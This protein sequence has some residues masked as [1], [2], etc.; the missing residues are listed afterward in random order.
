[1]Q[2]L[3]LASSSPR[4]KE[5]LQQ[6]GLDF[7]V[8]V[9]DIDET[10]H[11][12]EAA[13][14]YVERMARTKAQAVSRELKPLHTGESRYILA[15]DTIGVLDGEILIKPLDR[16]DFGRMMGRM[17]GCTHQVITS[18]SVA[19]QAAGTDATEQRLISV[20][21]DVRFKV[22]EADEIEAYWQ[23]SEPLDK[24]GGYGIQSKGALFVEGIQGSYSNVVGL[25]LQESAAL[26][27]EMGF[28]LWT[29]MQA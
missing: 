8:Q 18:V 24:A 2:L 25:P 15:A 10:P 3:I 26:L 13:L 17:S 28:E 9:A 19:R 14:A 27:Q 29:A 22:L 6:I 20:T 12:G 23:S 4:R 16:E 21:T 7:T 5:L 11:A 1:M